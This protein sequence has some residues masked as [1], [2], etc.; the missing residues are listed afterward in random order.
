MTFNTCRKT[1]A[2]KLVRQRPMVNK[3]FQKL[4]CNGF[5]GRGR[6]INKEEKIRLTCYSFID[7]SNY[8]DV[9]V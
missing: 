9:H 3:L 6:V 1:D 8:T 4:A 5:D 7:S 2:L